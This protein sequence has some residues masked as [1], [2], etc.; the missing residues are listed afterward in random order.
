M[1]LRDYI[2]CDDIRQEQNNKVSLMGLYN[3]R[4]NYRILSASNVDLKLPMP[5]R[6]ATFLRIE[7][8]KEDQRP[9]SFN[10]T[11]FLNEKVLADVSGPLKMDK[12][13]AIAN[14]SVNGEGLPLESGEIGFRLRLKKGTED[15]FNK[16]VKLALQI[17]IEKQS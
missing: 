4:I 3:D 11:L 13:Q 16:E 7:F 15:I 9:D 6:L 2:F 14:I 12:E 17:Q 10:F 8:E 5:M 1:K